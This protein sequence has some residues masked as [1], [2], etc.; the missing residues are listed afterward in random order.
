VVFGK[1]LFES[2]GDKRMSAE[3]NKNSKILAT[4]REERAMRLKG[5]L[6]HQTQI[7]LT[8]NFSRVKHIYPNSKA[9]VSQI[10]GFL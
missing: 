9:S 3:E 1:K 4:L 8:F 5:G 2:A 7:K 6:Y 10:F